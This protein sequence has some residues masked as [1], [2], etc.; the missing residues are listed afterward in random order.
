MLAVKSSNMP[1]KGINVYN[2]CKEVF[3]KS[4]RHDG[5]LSESDEANFQRN[6]QRIIPDGVVDERLVASEE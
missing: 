2:T 3:G 6:L 5:L 4:L 1:A